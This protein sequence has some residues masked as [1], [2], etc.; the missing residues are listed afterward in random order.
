MVADEQQNQLEKW[1]IE[2]GKIIKGMDL[3]VNDVVKHFEYWT[4]FK[5]LHNSSDSISSTGIR[6]KGRENSE[7]NQKYKIGHEMYGF[8]HDVR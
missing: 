1:K 7:G 8:Y 5:Y 6:K 4:L 2:K 3:N